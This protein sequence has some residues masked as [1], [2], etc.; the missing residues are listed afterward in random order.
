MLWAIALRHLVG[1]YDIMPDYRK[2]FHFLF[3]S[4]PTAILL[5][6]QKGAV[7]EMNPRAKQWFEGIPVHHIMSYFQFEANMPVVD[8]LA[9]VQQ[10]NVVQWEAQL[11]NPNKGDLDLIMGLELIEETDENYL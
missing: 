5:L 4:A 7:K 8:I 9:Q 11:H 2:L 1:K 10:E 6:D 3:K